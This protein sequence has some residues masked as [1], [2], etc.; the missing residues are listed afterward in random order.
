M[1][2]MAIGQR[3]HDAIGY[4]SR[5]GVSNIIWQPPWAVRDM[6]TAPTKGEPLEE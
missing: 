6:I 4:G 5:A 1:V 3:S 2:M